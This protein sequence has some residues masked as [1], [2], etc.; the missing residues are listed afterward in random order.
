LFAL[1]KAQARLVIVQG[2]FGFRETRQNRQGEE[3]YESET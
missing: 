1:V 2:G 3:E